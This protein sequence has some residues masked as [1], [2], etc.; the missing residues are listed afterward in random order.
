M[1]K[2]LYYENKIVKNTS[3]KLVTLFKSNLGYYIIVTKKLDTY[4]K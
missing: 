4:R 3:T 1:H 2:T